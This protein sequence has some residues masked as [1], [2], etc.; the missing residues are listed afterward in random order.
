[1]RNPTQLFS[2]AV[3]LCRDNMPVIAGVMLVGFVPLMV[4]NV[5]VISNNSERVGGVFEVLTLA[6]FVMSMFLIVAMLRVFQGRSLGVLSAYQ[7]A[8]P[9]FWRY[10]GM[11]VVSSVIIGIGLAFFIV[12]GVILSVV[13]MFSTAVLVIEDTTIMESLR[14]SRAYVRGRW[15]AVFGRIVPVVF[16][17][18]SAEVGFVFGFPNDTPVGFVAYWLWSFVIS[19][20]VVAYWYELYKDARATAVIE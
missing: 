15:W 7:A 1:M 14:R 13:W 20:I 2:A 12:P 4:Q 16:I 9:F 8:L 10:V 5:L 18:G 19:P 3:A 6:G 11:T 17:V